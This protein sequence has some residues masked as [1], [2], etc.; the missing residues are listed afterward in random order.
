MLGQKKST[1]TG[2]ALIEKQQAD[3]MSEYYSEYLLWNLSK[4][5]WIWIKYNACSV[6]CE[7]RCEKYDERTV[8]CAL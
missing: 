1:V 6:M 4:L 3:I 2:T 5:G 7:V 8:M